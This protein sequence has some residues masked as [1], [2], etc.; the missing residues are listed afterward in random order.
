M[1]APNIVPASIPSFEHITLVAVALTPAACGAA[2][3]TEQTFT[4]TGLS[5]GDSLQNQ[6]IILN[7]YKP[8]AQTGLA[9][10][11]SRVT[12]ANTVAIQFINPTAGSITPTA[13]ETYTFTVFRPCQLAQA[14]A[15]VV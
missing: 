2:T 5:V 9:L 7:V 13:G 8:T 15:T 12:A 11:Q 1:A 6:D 14:N 4:V 3:A 10:G